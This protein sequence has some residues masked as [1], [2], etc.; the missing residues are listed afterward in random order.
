MSKPKTLLIFPPYWEPSMPYLSLPSLT[1]YLR[2][3]GYEIDQWDLN[4]AFHEKLLDADYLNDRITARDSILKQQNIDSEKMRAFL[5]QTSHAKKTFKTELFY[6]PYMLAQAGEIWHKACTM[7]NCLYPG[8]RLSVHEFEMEERFTSSEAVIQATQNR[9]ANPF[10]EYYELHVLPEIAKDPPALL[11]LSIARDTQ[12]IP[13]F[14][15]AKLVREH[16]PQIHVTVGGCYFTKIAD[17]L[18]QDQHPAFTH[19]IHSAV[20]G[21]GED[22]LLKLVQALEGLH[23]LDQVPGL[24]HL[25]PD[26]GKV[27]TNGFGPAVSMNDIQTPD[28]DG[29]DLENYWSPDLFFPILGSRDCYWKD[30]TF[31]DHYMQYAG[32][33]SRKPHLIAED[34][35]TLNKK[36]GVRNF[37]FC[38]ETISPNLGRRLAAEIKERKLDIHWYGM[39]RLQKGFDAE[40]AKVWRESGCLYLLMGLESAS[41]ELAKKMIKGTE[42]RLTEEVYQNLHE[43]DI[44]TFAF[45]FFGFPGETIATATETLDYIREHQEI[46]NSVGG[47]VFV[48]KKNSPIY[49]NRTEF[50]ITDVDPQD[51]A[52]DWISSLRFELSEGMNTEEAFYFHKRYDEEIW[53]LYKGAFWIKHSRISVFLYLVRFGKEWMVNHSQQ[54]DPAENDLKQAQAYFAEKNL[55]AAQ[56]LLEQVLVRMPQHVY[57]LNYLGLIAIENGQMAAAQNYFKEALQLGPSYPEALLSMGKWHQ[58]QGDH[59]KAIESLRQALGFNITAAEIYYRLA[60]SL[61]QHAPQQNQTEIETLTR[62]AM[63]LSK[64]DQNIGGNAFYPCLGLNE[65]YAKICP[66]TAV[67]LPA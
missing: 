23:G 26:S 31:C 28:F 67:P 15:L 43:A 49:R 14:T 59:P 34:L 55:D 17:G 66:Q 24:I 36:Y 13:A 29:L 62:R 6:S 4:L 51:L 7:I 35:E 32:F 56:T 27:I 37:Q 63:I 61:Q 33:R 11:G 30:C 40:T 39:A 10:I 44:F 9:L 2:H 22:P 53:N 3:H 20:K 21:E 58:S 46:I 64:I 12:I 60:E 48:L 18:K 57:A 50:G 42:N 47:G 54:Q 8:A 5:P 38:D 65:F 45:L 1:S 16:F 41:A 52:D 25:D 19:L